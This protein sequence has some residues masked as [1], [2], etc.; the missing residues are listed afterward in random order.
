MLTKWLAILLVGWVL[1]HGYFASQLGTPEFTKDSWLDILDAVIFSTNLEF[2][3]VRN[4]AYGFSSDGS[5]QKRDTWRVHAVYATFAIAFASAICSSIIYSALVPAPDDSAVAEKE[6]SDTLELDGNEGQMVMLYQELSDDEPGLLCADHGP[7]TARTG[8]AL[9]QD[10]EGGTY[11]VRFTDGEEPE[12]GIFPLHQL[13]PDFSKDE[14]DTM[15]QPCCS[16]W[17]HLEE[18]E[19]GGDRLLLFERRAQVLD[20][21]RSLLCLQLPF[22][23]WRLYFNSFQLDFVAWGGTTMLIGKN[24]LW[25]LLDIVKILS[26]GRPDAVL[27]RCR[28]VEYLQKA[29]NSKLGQ[30]W[31]GPSGLV[32]F[33]VEIAGSLRAKRL[34]HREMK[35][36]QHIE[37]LI[38]E[39]QKTKNH[40]LYATRLQEV[41]RELVV[42]QEKKQFTFP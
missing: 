8:R 27:C 22:L 4:P 24:A 34:Q 26:C 6:V 36:Q 10:L 40:Q 14:S 17:L 13:N 20:A 19:T 33:M 9:R 28:P 38:T 7:R 42:I 16:G 37:W 31:V 35:I 32:A 1:R 12:T 15:D 18:L 29:T 25:G 11:L 23:V 2:P 39:S 21:F 3:Y 30:V 5:P 41:Q